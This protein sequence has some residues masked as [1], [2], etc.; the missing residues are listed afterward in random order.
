MHLASDSTWP[1]IMLCLSVFH[2]I[3][4]SS[5]LADYCT[6]TMIII[7]GRVVVRH[8]RLEP[9]SLLMPSLTADYCRANSSVLPAFSLNCLMQSMSYRFDC[10]INANSNILLIILTSSACVIK[11]RLWGRRTATLLSPSSVPP[12]VPFSRSVVSLRIRSRLYSHY[13]ASP[14]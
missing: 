6:Y 1:T 2:C 14:F 13:K 10:T 9:P 5:S 12:A 11:N 7:T 4:F 8:F 3:V